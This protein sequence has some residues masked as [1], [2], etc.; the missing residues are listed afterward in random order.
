MRL[1]A[2][3]S[4]RGTAAA[5]PKTAFEAAQPATRPSEPGAAPV[6]S[7]SMRLEAAAPSREPD[8]AG[9]EAAAEALAENVWTILKR[10]LATEVERMG[11]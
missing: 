11:L 8:A 9:G 2:G 7:V 5:V 1:P 10:R 4:A 3:E 6:P